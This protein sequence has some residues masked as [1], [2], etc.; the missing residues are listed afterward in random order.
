[1][2]QPVCGLFV[3]A[4]RLLIVWPTLLIGRETATIWKDVVLKDAAQVLGTQGWNRRTADSGNRRCRLRKA[5]ARVRE[6]P[7]RLT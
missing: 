6:G 3:P 2:S 4:V 1:M 5:R 7:Q